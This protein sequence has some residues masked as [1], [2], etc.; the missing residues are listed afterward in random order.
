MV[1]Y[2]PPSSFDDDDPKL[3]DAWREWWRPPAECADDHLIA[4]L[5]EHYTR[6]EPPPCR[7]CGGPLTVARA[8]SGR[9]LYACSPLTDGPSEAGHLIEKAGRGSLAQDR[10]AEDDHYRRSYWEQPRRGD[11]DVLELVARFR[12]IAGVA[13]P[14]SPTVA[15]C[16]GCLRPIATIG[17]AE[18][19]VTYRFDGDGGVRCADCL[20]AGGAA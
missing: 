13:A 7:V 19:P 6:D 1:G 8:G 11:D 15:A 4:R 5:V 16:R 18:G 9:T 17:P 14:S 10:D 3:A 12:R 2:A 20:A